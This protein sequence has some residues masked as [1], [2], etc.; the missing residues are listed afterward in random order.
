MKI[1]A[2]KTEAVQPGQHQLDDLIDKYIQRLPERTVLAVSSKV[3]SI[4]EGQIV[5]INTTD[6]QKLLREEADY[7]RSPRSNPHNYTVTIKNNQLI[8]AA[9]VDYS[10]GHYVLWPADPQHTT[11]ML[12]RHL[13]ARFKHPVGVILTDNHSVPLR[14]GTT[15]F[16]LAH[17]GFEALKNYIGH[18]DVFGHRIGFKMTNVADALAAS[19]VLAMGDGAEQQPIAIIEDPA[20]VVFQNRDPSKD[21]LA[22]QT[23]EPSDDL[24]SELLLG[25]PW[26]KSP[27]KLVS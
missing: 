5:D 22:L 18:P 10:D 1:T 4:C 16:A 12:R 11:N 2:I 17:S 3:V 21:E 7:Y 19:A 13:V 9:G 26:D 8:A 27:D 23:V 24:Y 20:S 6:R 15:G 14:R 25:V